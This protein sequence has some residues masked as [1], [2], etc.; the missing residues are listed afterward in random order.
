MAISYNKLWKILID[1]NLNKTQLMSKCGI[2]SA[3]L[4]RL[5]KN[6]GVSLKVL[7][8]I[9]VSLKCEIGDIMEFTEN[10]GDEV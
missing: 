4:A 1:N 2:T 3:S 7:E 9:C 10:Q 5:S 8:R 6:Q